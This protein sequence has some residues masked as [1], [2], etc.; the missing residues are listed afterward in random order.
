MVRAMQRFAISVDQAGKLKNSRVSDDGPSAS[1]SAAASVEIM[2][3]SLQIWA[4]KC[5]TCL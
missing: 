4:L 1:Q 5:K 3:K 2:L